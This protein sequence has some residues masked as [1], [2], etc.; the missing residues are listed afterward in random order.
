[1]LNQK[2]GA[3]KVKFNGCG[4]STA[5]R[6]STTGF[7]LVAALSL[8]STGRALS[9]ENDRV[10]DEPLEESM[11]LEE[12]I[13]TA[14]LRPEPL[15]TVP[16][17]VDVIK[18]EWLE[19]YAVRTFEELSQ[20][21]PNFTVNET[22]IDTNI[23][24]RGI[25]S[26][27]NQGFEQSVGMFSDGV[28]W[29]RAR[30]ARVP[31]FDVERIEV[32]KGP[33]GI[34]FGKNT[35]AGAVNIIT[36]KPSRETEGS[37]SAYYEP[38]AAEFIVEGIF[39][40]RLGKDWMGR[41]SLRGASMD[42]WVHNTAIDADEPDREETFLRGTLV[43]EAS[44]DVELVFKY[45][46]GSLD[47][48]GSPM[49]ITEAGEFGS[50]FSAFDPLFEDR[51]NDQRSVGGNGVFI[52]PESSDTDTQ[53]A[54][55]TINWQ[56][57]EFNLTAITGYSAYDFEDVFDADISAL[58]Q[59][60]KVF[61]SD[62]QQWSQ[63]IRL[64]SPL[65]DPGGIEYVVGIYWQD[66]DLD[67]V[68]RDDIDLSLLGAPAGS[69]YYITD[70]SA[71]SWAIFTQATWH[72][73]ETFRI[74]GG[75]RWSNEDK[76]ASR[77]LTVTDLGTTNPNPELEPFF[78]FALGTFPHDLKGS[79]SENHLLP[80]INLQ[81]DANHNT[82]FYASYS[83]G[84]KGGGFDEQLTSGNRDDWEFD[85]EQVDAH[86]AGVKMSFLE[87]RATLNAAIFRSEYTDLQVSA[88]D[89]IA[90]FVV[91]N[92][93]SATSQGVEL[94][95]RFRVTPALTAGISIAYLDAKY[96]S[97]ENA[98]CT[99]QQTADHA[100]SGNPPPCLQDLSGRRPLYSPKWSGNLYGRHVHRFAGWAAKYELNSSLE[101]NFTDSYFITQDL[102][103]NLEQDSFGKINLRVAL[104]AVQKGWEV[105]LVGKNL[106]DKQTASFG[107]DVPILNGAYFK[108]ADRPRTIAIQAIYQF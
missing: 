96:D 39:S 102:D 61:G 47:V 108:F 5:R 75:L 78:G 106:T 15:L 105:A 90:G 71:T 19:N 25:G 76:R 77:S 33:Q 85:D 6:W 38:D 68:T 53:N 54:A 40:G 41:I 2:I 82:M 37:V 3:T 45:E 43:W 50:L 13:V 23:F 91:G 70:Q 9:Q 4:P 58:S 16:V 31:F 49:Q 67:V 84:S 20:S 94:E 101:F 11:V 17:S 89:G 22:P 24:I 57:E 87:R 10:E 55:L 62:F 107:N 8:I 69:R 73:S 66:N 1:M 21:V 27:E 29:G 83:K 98:N 14:Q 64:I 35:S 93:A 63:E 103:P 81:W 32:L 97:F 92:A 7:L 88:F 79:R 12:V 100:M 99:A 59:A 34:L 95:S 86:E 56:L 72:L 42:G 28:Y 46:Y 36:A 74:T 51:L 60:Q 30:Q 48:K 65:A 26:P 18:G 80:S 52:A 104:V 44:D